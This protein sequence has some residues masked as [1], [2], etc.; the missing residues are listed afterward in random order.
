MERSR[1][2]LNVRAYHVNEERR[3]EREVELMRVSKLKHKRHAQIETN[4]EKRK[5]IIKANATVCCSD[6]RH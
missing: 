3:V 5:R 1:Q 6:M 2:L 4:G